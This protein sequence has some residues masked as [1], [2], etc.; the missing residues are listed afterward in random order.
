M[1]MIN[2]LLSD[3]DECND[4]DICGDR[5]RCTNTIGGYECDCADGY[6]VAGTGDS[7]WC[8]GNKHMGNFY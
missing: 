5:K 2:V 3:K 8:Q 6:Q 1:T 7:V 4:L